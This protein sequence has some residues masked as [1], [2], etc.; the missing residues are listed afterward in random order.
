KSRVKSV[1]PTPTPTAAADDEGD[2]DG[3]PALAS[4][5]A[6][7]HRFGSPAHIAQMQEGRECNRSSTGGRVGGGS[8]AGARQRRALVPRP[9]RQSSEWQPS[10]EWL[11]QL[12][13]PGD[14]S[15]S[16]SAR[17]S[18]SASRSSSEATS[19][20]GPAPAAP[21]RNRHSHASSSS[22]SAGGG[23]GGGAGGGR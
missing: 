21:S 10:S 13:P 2:G 22:S 11:D 16:A 12:L 14:A 5:P 20:P 18:M 7:D 8:V 15:P 19:A 1:T 23:G 6:A 9:L 3:D 17:L 4:L